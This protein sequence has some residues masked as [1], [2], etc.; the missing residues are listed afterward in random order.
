[1]AGF[2]LICCAVNMGN[3]SKVWRISKKYGI[4]GATISIGRGAVRSPLM[5]FFAIDE[6]RKEIVSMV[7]EDE[8][9]GEAIKGISAEMK[10]EKPHH[11]IAFLYSVREFIGSKNPVSAIKTADTYTKDDIKTSSF[12]AVNDIE[13][14]FT[15]ADNSSKITDGGKGMYNIIFVIVEKGKAEDVIEAA[16]KAGS[17]GGTIINARGAGI[18][19]VQKFFSVEIEP[20]KEEVFIITRSDNKDKIVN[21]IRE[22]LKI[23]EPGNGILYVLD[24]NEVYGLHG[25]S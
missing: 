9:A 4:K 11:G 21:S 25:A 23:D 12:S 19:E 8:L 14:P 3:A 16:N 10:F 6:E 15:A 18:H 7:V 17:T 2:S 1:M 5:K 13:T 24:V 22:H 20:E